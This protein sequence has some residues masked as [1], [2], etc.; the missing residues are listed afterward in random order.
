MIVATSG[1][2]PAYGTRI[3]LGD[4]VLESLAEGLRT[5]RL[6]SLWHHDIRQPA[7][8]RILD[9]GLR[10]RPDGE[11]E[12]WALVEVDSDQWSAYQANLDAAGAPGGVSFSGSE[13]LAELPA[14][15]GTDEVYTH[16]SADMGHWSDQE[17]L[18]AAEELRRLGVVSAGRRFEF[19]HDPRAVVD[20]LFALKE[21]GLPI[22]LGVASNVLYE[23]LKRFLR[24]DKPTIFHFEVRDKDQWVRAYLETDDEAV[25]E[26]AIDTFERLVLG[27]TSTWDDDEGG[28]TD[29][30]R[31]S[32][33]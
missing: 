6:G 1:P 31:D 14:L 32:S 17:I 13:P 11:R 18:E 12:V 3:Q 33:D 22:F 27:T 9:A 21:I 7:D 5:G 4:A 28:W 29:A 20:L 24:H 19:A 30:G 25:L 10:V 23:P 2:F 26:R 15:S 8:F 16:I